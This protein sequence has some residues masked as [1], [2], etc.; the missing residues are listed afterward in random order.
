MY[1]PIFGFTEN[2]ALKVFD[3]ILTAI[4]N[5]FAWL[6]ILVMPEDGAADAE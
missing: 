1:G 5:F 2:D 4:K 3:A 6:G